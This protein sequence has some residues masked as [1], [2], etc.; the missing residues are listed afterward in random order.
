MNALEKARS[1]LEAAEMQ[2][3]GNNPARA[4]ETREIALGWL[5]LARLQHAIGGED[6]KPT[7]P[8]QPQR[9][10]RVVDAPQPRRPR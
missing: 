8:V 4:T 7:A 10:P 3:N 1:L 2:L 9:E 6:P 5:T